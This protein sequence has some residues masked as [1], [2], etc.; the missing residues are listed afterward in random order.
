MSACR[1]CRIKR[2]AE[3]YRIL[4]VIVCSL[5]VVSVL[6]NMLTLN[7][8]RAA[9]D[10]AEQA[11]SVAENS[12][13]IA[14]E[15]IGKLLEQTVA[16]VH[17]NRSDAEYL[18]NVTWGEAR[19]CSV[20]EQAAVMWCVLNRVDSSSY[21]NSVAEV[22]TQRHQFE[23]YSEN[24]PVTEELLELAYSV[25]YYWSTGDDSG[26]VLPAEYLYFTGDGERNHFYKSW[27]V[28]TG[29]WDWSLPSPYKEQ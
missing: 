20:T 5:L 18:A 10:Q 22:V 8:L 27:G 6:L 4:F 23:G 25:L 21:P 13:V 9:T 11:I 19:G 28:N 16:D 7:R 17:I 2:D 15:A 29:S 3:K 1:T 14:D 12:Q 26:R 24:N